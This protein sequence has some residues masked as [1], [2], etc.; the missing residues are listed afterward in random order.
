M[1]RRTKAREC[2]FQILYQREISGEA[3]PKV[4]A[5][6]WQV[7]SGTAPMRAMAER[8][9]VGAQGRAQELDREIVA[10]AANWRLDRMAPVDRTILRLGAYE[11]LA[12]PETPPAVVL[13]EAIE[14]AKR[15]G[16]ADSPAFVNGV[17]DA[18]R[19]QVRPPARPKKGRARGEEQR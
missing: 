17:L 19:R 9:A 11:L 2:A 18:I 6:F 14:L 1:G 5:A 3:M 7:R 16:E 12:E 4:I 15:F 13:D 10:A 8:L